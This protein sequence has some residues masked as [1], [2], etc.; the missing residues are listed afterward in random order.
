[1]R[2]PSG[3]HDGGSLVIRREQVAYLPQTST[4]IGKNVADAI[5]LP[6]LLKVRRERVGR[7]PEEVLPDEKIRALL[8]R[9]GCEDIQLDRKPLKLSGGQAARVCLARTG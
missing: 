2:N 9:M 1:M 5:H 3:N 7:S 4:I 6:W 8:D